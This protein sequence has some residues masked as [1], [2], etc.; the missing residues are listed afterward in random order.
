M[1]FKAINEVA[2]AKRAKSKR[3][4]FYTPLELVEQ[5]V[6]AA[7]IHDESRCLEPSAGDGRIVHALIQAGAQVV[8][9][10]EIEESLHPVITKLGGKMIGFDFLEHKEEDDAVRDA[11][12]Y[13][14][15]VMNPPFKGKEWKKHL[16][17]AWT[18]LRPGGRLVAVLPDLAKIIL[19]PG[20][21]KLEGCD[22]CNFETIN[23]KAFKDYETSTRTI[24]ITAHKDDGNKHD[25]VEGFK[26]H[27]TYS[28]AITIG[29][30]GD[31]YKK[32]GE[33]SNGDIRQEYLK[34]N[35]DG[36]HC[37][38]GIDWSEVYGYLRID[39]WGSDGKVSGKGV[40]EGKSLHGKHRD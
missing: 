38:Y 1:S 13:H 9:A 17:H 29:S 31:I 24:L 22:L 2:E 10:C 12:R 15:I 19:L 35:Q 4:A 23:P 14:A 30:D 3:A 36:G 37:D 33:L 11:S 18:F 40:G 39:L 34:M 8:H 27:V 16:E 32:R 5:M 20:E 26:N 21:I 25:K 7:G 28:V 6:E